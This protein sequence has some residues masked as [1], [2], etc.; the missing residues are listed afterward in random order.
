MSDII[1]LLSDSVANQI[2][3]GEVIQRPASLLKELME[4][5]ID[6]GATDIKV[7]VKDAGRTLVQVLDNGSGMSETDARMAFE[8]HATSK[9][10]SAS[11]LFSLRTMGFRGE[12][13]ASIAAVAQVELNTRKHQNELGTRIVIAGS[14]IELQEPVNCPPGS[15]F[16]VKNLFF[17]VPARR[18]FLKSNAT[19]L[20]HIINEFQRVALAHPEI[21]FTLTH[22]NQPVFNLQ[23]GNLKVR[24]GGIMGKQTPSNLIPVS[25]D[26]SI[27]N[28]NG[29]TG[30]PQAA[31]KTPG[32]QF[33]F[34]NKRYMRHP[35][36]HK[37]VMDAYSNL[38]AHDASPSYFL[39]FE[40]DPELIDVNIHPTKTEIKFEDEK[41]IWKILNATIREGLGKF[42]EIPSIDFD[43]EGQ[44][45]IPLP[46][47]NQE[48]NIPSTRI[49]SNFNPFSNEINHNQIHD[50]NNSKN[51]ETLYRDFE[52]SDEEKIDTSLNT[53]TIPSGGI[54]ETELSISPRSITDFPVLES[55]YFQIKNRFILTPVKSGLMVIDQRRAHERILF[56][57][58]LQSVNTNRS[59]SQQI[60]FPETLSFNAEDTILLREISPDLKV[61]GIELDETSEGNFLIMG[62]PPEL[63]NTN[64][65]I[66]IE[67]LLDAYK[68]GEVN[69]ENQ[70]REQ[71]A[72]ILARDACMYHGESLT[73]NEIVSLV[74]RLFRCQKPNYTHSGKPVIS[75]ITNN[76]LDDRFT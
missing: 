35:Y 12:A 13:L 55:T 61:F 21:G 16:I 43:T 53:I 18:R 60:L 30:K 3:A 57:Q 63:E 59:A 23:P 76:E 56:E 32:E 74:N 20:R 40:I 4:N 51:W 33:F 10:K 64:N 28:I 19:E 49:N 62:L 68:N 24:I 54:I 47:K 1:Q 70:I 72:A 29:F 11:D 25:I 50:K 45:N 9:I 46:G 36:L 42:N 22:N 2:A 66:I 52:I 27:V 34:V 71:M 8:R 38:I 44:I 75:I 15:N 69:P 39:F 31:R 17:N 67:K 7:F 6:A 65:K 73:S 58:F 41:M 14:E 5:C 26:A 37:S 48:I